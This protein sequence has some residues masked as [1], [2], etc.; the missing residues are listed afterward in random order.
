MRIIAGKHRGRVL[1]EFKGRE[2]RPTSDRAKEAL[3]NI[4]QFDIAGSEF[5]DLYSGTGGI[6]LEALSRGAERVVFVDNSRE[7]VKLLKE[8]LAYLKEQAE[9]VE[10]DALS[11][12][13]LSKDKFDLIFLDPPYSVNA[14]EVV[15]TAIKRGLLKDGGRIIY[16]HSEDFEAVVLSAEKVDSRKY[17]IAV[18]DFSFRKRREPIRKGGIMRKCVFAGTFDPVTK[19]HEEVIAKCSAMFDEVIVAICVNVNKTAMFPIEKRLE[20]LE[21]TCRKYGNVKVVYHEGLLVDLLKK[22]GAVYNVRGLRNGK[23]YE[24]ENEMN[25]VNSE[26]MPEI[27]TVYIPCGNMNVQVSSSIVRELLRFNRDVK[28][29]VPEEI[30]DLIR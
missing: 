30:A 14:T 11:F 26:L 8:N 18:F 15:E 28:R 29:Y 22:E 17:G 12:V 23:D 27:V 9:V 19:G 4:L 13:S 7:S 2:I 20:F 1:K 6:G 24:Y 21:K 10:S 25:F 16:E 3:F 5:L